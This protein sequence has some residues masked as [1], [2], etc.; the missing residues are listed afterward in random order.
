MLGY[1]LRKRTI[2]AGFG[3]LLSRFFELKSEVDGVRGDKSFDIAAPESPKHHPDPYEIFSDASWTFLAVAST[4]PNLTYPAR[5]L[6]DEG[7]HP[8]TN[9]IMK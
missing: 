1:F 3:A 4:L 7:E 8:P 9:R 2:C 6:A 5:P